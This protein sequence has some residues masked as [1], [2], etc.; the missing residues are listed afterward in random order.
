MDFVF[1]DIPSASALVERVWRTHSEGGGSFISSAGTNMELVVT[2]QASQT[3]VTMRGPETR[4][5]LAPV[6]EDAEFLGITFKL[7]AFLPHLP[8]QLLI[9][10]SLNLPE[11]SSKSF[12]LNGAV[13]Q[14]P[15]YNNADVF[16]DRLVRDGLL[17]RDPVVEA[18]LQGQPH[19]LSL[20][21]LQYR[22]LRATG[23]THKTIQQIER[24]RR[25]A[26][27]LEQG[28]SILDT[29]Y[30][31]GYYDQAHL[32]RSLKHFIGRTPAQ[33]TRQMISDSSRTAAAQN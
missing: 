22:F 15:D 2:R 12:W 25:A 10:G 31:A 21:S 30:A 1:E 14:F 16:V 9:D 7:G 27:L 24:A 33:I 3:T 4:A 13:W 6:P 20:R 23:L 26:A 19:D 29:V 5:S 28:V 17:V 11:A 8:T 18:V 32:T